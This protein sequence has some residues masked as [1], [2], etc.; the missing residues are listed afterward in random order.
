[1]SDQPPPVLMIRP[2]GL[3]EILDAA[4]KLTRRHLKALML[5]MVLVATPIAILNTL[6][7]A[8]TTEYCGPGCF[9]V[10]QGSRYVANDGAYYAGVGA[11]LLL[12]GV[13][14]LLTQIAC[15]RILANGYLGRPTTAGESLGYAARRGPSV[16]WL[17]LV[18]GVL[19]LLAYLC[20]IIPGI[21]FTYAWGLAIPALMV[22][23][24]RGRQALK[25]SRALVRDH[26]WSVF[27]ATTIAS[28]LAGVIGGVF[29]LL[30]AGALFFGVDEG[31]TLGM[32][33]VTIANIIGTV[34]TT[35]FAAAVTVL[36]YF[37]LRVRKE[38]F[39]LVLMAER[40][41]GEDA[42]SPRVAGPPPPG[43]MPVAD[44]PPP[45]SFA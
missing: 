29:G 33:L 22:E 42:L 14:Y 5:V 13:Q 16:I 10:D 8:S 30:A 11:Q 32:S 6:I 15:F 17:G 3:G 43:A 40:M 18:M 24:R 38:S 1:M 27:G 21:Y 34:I 9:E 25:R 31:S 4:I 36:L 19:L 12:M 7:D 37:D 44:L 26:W 39:D 20:L 41:G 2:L 23:N 45:P 35:P 28:V